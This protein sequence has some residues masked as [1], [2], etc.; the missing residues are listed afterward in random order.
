MGPRAALSCTRPRRVYARS[1]SCSTPR[2]PAADSRGHRVVLAASYE[3]RAS[4]S[5]PGCQH[6][7]RAALPGPGFS[8]GHF[9]EYQ[10][11]ATQ[12]MDVLGAF[13]A[14]CRT[15]LHRRGVPRC[16]RCPTPLRSPT[17]SLPPS[18]G[19]SGRTSGLPLSIGWPHQTPGKWLPRCQADGLVVVGPDARRSSW[20]PAGRADMGV[21]PVTG[22]TA[23]AGIRTWRAGGGTRALLDHLL[24]RTI[25]K[26]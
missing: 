19:A 11:S 15:G 20:P 23:T 9:R 10:R 8:S 3:A 2:S 25:G 14:G 22:P 24:G 12:V 5:R 26:D 16:G 18:A 1:S 17:P 7:G 4:A 21:G 13:T 6:G